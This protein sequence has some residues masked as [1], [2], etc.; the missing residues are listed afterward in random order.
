M[1][2][3]CYTVAQLLVLLQMPKTTFER[4]LRQHDLPFLV[5]LLPRLGHNRR[6]R[7]DLVDQYLA[8]QWG[9]RA[10]TVARHL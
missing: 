3:R 8:G 1:A 2:S 10:S 6:Y 5:E 9:R 4:L 7:A